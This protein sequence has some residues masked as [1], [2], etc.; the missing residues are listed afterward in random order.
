M[1]KQTIIINHATLQNENFV[2]IRKI[3]IQ[4]YGK[5]YANNS[6]SQLPISS[7]FKRFKM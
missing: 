7:I 1:Y 5:R 6:N 3:S 4:T 2:N